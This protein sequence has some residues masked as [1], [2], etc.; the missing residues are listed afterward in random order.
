MVNAN[1][2]EVGRVKNPM[3]SI[4]APIDSEK[5][6]KKPKGTLSSSGPSH[7]VKLFPKD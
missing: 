4:S 6:A 5:V 2:N 1:K 7:L 3:A